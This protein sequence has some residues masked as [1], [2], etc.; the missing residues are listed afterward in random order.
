[1][2]DYL[3]L[4]DEVEREIAQG[5]W[6]PGERLPPQREFAFRRGV[7]A[8]TASRVYGELMRRGLTVGE[9]GRGTFIRATDRAIVETALSEPR[10]PLVDLEMNFPTLPDQ[11]ERL[12]P[13]LTMLSR[14]D[15]L[16]L[17]LAPTTIRGSADSQQ[18]A[19]KMLAGP[20]W[21]P[22]ADS[23]RFAAGGRQAIA[24]A[25]AACVPP[26]ETLGVE[27]LTYPV[28]KGIA[29][30][31]GVRIVPIA[32]DE[33]GLSPDALQQTHRGSGLR[34]LYLQP[35]LHNPLGV[36]MSQSR[37]RVL[38]DA[39]QRLE[40]TAIEDAVYRFLAP[41]EA[42]LAAYA[43]DR[44]IMVDSLSKRLAPG[45][46]LGFLAAPDAVVE[47]VACACRQ[48]GW[49]ATG[50]AI[51][52]GIRWIAE[53][54]VEEVAALKR[55]DAM[56][57]QSIARRKLAAWNPKGD[58][59]AYHLWLDLPEGWRADTFIAAAAQ[60]GISLVPGA[61]FAVGR[62]HAPNA[63]RLALASPPVAS[64][65]WSL[66]SLVRLLNAPGD[67]IVE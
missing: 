5:R 46:T 55:E 12:S 21:T 33:D 30:R 11:A 38:A 6:R 40:L 29:A 7:A 35:S 52:A 26:G 9:V 45:L 1:M 44:V 54:I 61:A 64:L 2:I 65:Q 8:S 36:T 22:A 27:A 25:I 28:V 51:K 48:G 43:P 39:L 19:A 23:I 14:P 60:R 20:Q 34:A 13:V 42:P 67:S 49:G 53:G 37:R 41:N 47:A 18:I 3:R 62:G 56:A 17:A 50:F 4:A 66:D 57:R 63:V 10:F 59:R 58:T 24:A 32:M 16:R 15:L 31:L